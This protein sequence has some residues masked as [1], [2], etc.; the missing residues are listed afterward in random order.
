MYEQR[1]RLQEFLHSPRF[2]ILA[3]LLII[4]LIVGVVLLLLKPA[5][6]NNIT[7]PKAPVTNFSDFFPDLDDVYRQELEQSLYAQIN[8]D[9]N[10]SSSVSATI[11]EGSLNTVDY[12][13]YHTG[14][15]IIDIEDLQLSY[16]VSFQYGTFAGLEIEPIAFATFY[17]PTES[18]LVYPAFTCSAQTGYVR[19]TTAGLKQTEIAEQNLSNQ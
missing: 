4:G 17:C 2:F 14:D 19:A 10:L 1:S 5:P 7:I 16:L 13:Q 15:F 12:N 3:G 18:Q 9:S 8:T 11:R 6:D